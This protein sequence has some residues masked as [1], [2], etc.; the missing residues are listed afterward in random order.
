MNIDVLIGQ[1]NNVDNAVKV[2]LALG[3]DGEK[4]EYHRCGNYLTFPRMGGDNKKGMVLYLDKLHYVGTTSGTSGSI[5]SLVMDVK[6]CGFGEAV[7]YV[8]SVLGV[9]SDVPIRRPFG[10]FYQNVEDD[11]TATNIPEISDSC[12]KFFQ[13]NYSQMFFKDGVDF[14]SQEFFKVGYSHED[15]AVLIPIYSIDGKLIGC[16]GRR[17]GVVDMNDRWF[18]KYRYPKSKTIYGYSQNYA[19]IVKADSVFVFEAEKSV[20]Q[21]RSFGVKQA[22]AVGGHSISRSQA[23][24]LKALGCKNICI[25]FDEGVN[26][27]DVRFQASK[28]KT[29]DNNVYVVLDKKNKYL[30]AGNKDS[31]SDMGG[32]IFRK[33]VKECSCK[34]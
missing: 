22:V 1:L 14:K 10:G 24:Y 33:L 31:P 17:N 4:M 19:D 26:S 20:M 12:I 27:D 6:K 23:Y 2:L 15:D 32:E 18:M 8:G 11:V 30:R 7:Q 16:K 3:F 9:D 5:F 28:V 25:A 13:G 34:I 21:C 29:K